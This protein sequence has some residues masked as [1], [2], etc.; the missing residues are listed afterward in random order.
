L[1]YFRHE[2]AGNQITVYPFVCWHIGARQSDD[3]FIR[4]MVQRV[5]D[6]PLARWFYMG[7]AGECVTKASKGDV[8]HQTMD[9]TEQ[10]KY[11]AALVAPIKH[12]GLFGVRGNHGH[13]VFKETGMEFDEALC[14]RVGIPYLGISAFW[15][16]VL[17]RA[18]SN[19]VCAFDIFTH[20]GTDSGATL[21]SKVNK[22]KALEQLVVADA[23]FSAHS[24]I[25]CEIPPRHIATLVDNTR[26]QE[27]VKWLTTH[28][29]ICGC[30]YDSRSGYA[31]DKGYSPILPA[32][33]AVTFKHHRAGN[34]EE[35]RQS[36]E[37]WRSDA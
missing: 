37:I 16:L 19:S 6:D 15:H 20:H 1:K 25:C 33:L 29:Y 28:E 4:E 21:S 13:R 8:F 2:V 34:V 9:L 31:E 18:G 23:I 10:A 32:H 17:K 27:K 7:D 14:L 11:F 5:K 3:K 24:H 36:C 12:K 35:R 26:A 30:A 22:A